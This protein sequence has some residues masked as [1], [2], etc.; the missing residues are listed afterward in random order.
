MSKEAAREFYT[1]VRDMREAQRS[2]YAARS[3]ENKAKYLDKAKALER[4]VDERIVRTELTLAKMSGQ[5]EVWKKRQPA[6]VLRL[7]QEL[8]LDVVKYG[9]KDM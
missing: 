5:A 2:Y 4:K 3:K 7:M 6:S 8:N 1:L 9:D